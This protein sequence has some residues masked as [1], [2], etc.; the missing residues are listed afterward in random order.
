MKN[1]VLRISVSLLGLILTF[2]ILV[3]LSY[4][5]QP[6]LQA[7]PDSVLF[8]VLVVFTSVAGVP[9]GGGTASLLPMAIV[10]SYL[11]LG[12]LPAAWI[13]FLSQLLAAIIEPQIPGP[14]V[15]ARPSDRITFITRFSTNAALQTMSILIAGTL[16]EK[17]GGQVPLMAVELPDIVPLLALG[18]TFLL[19]NYVG[20]GL[21][22][23]SRGRTQ[24]ETYIRAIDGLFGYEGIPLS[25]APL[26]ALVATRLGTWAFLSLTVGIMAV[27]VVARSLA[28]TSLRLQRRV[29]ELD[30]LLEVSQALSASL[31]LKTILLAIHAQI[32]ELMPAD[33]FYLALYNPA[34]NE[35]SFPLYIED[36][37]EI[38]R[39]A[40]R[41]GRGLTEY[42]LK[43]GKPLLS[44]ETTD[45]TRRKLGLQPATHPAL[46]WLGVPIL[47]GQ[48]PIGVIA[49]QSYLDRHLYDLNHQKVLAAVAAQAGIAIQNTQLFARTDEALAFRVQ[50]LNSILRATQDGI[51]FL[52]QQGKVLAANRALAGFLHV[53]QLELLAMELVTPLGSDGEPLFGLIGYQWEELQHDLQLILQGDCEPQKVTIHL[54]G[55]PDRYL[56]RTLTGVRGE[57]GEIT[58]WLFV[59]RDRTD[60]VKAARMQEDL[61]QMIVHDLPAPLGI[62]QGGL[63]MVT[64]IHPRAESEPKNI[65]QENDQVVALLKKSTGR[66]VG[67]VDQLLDIHKLESGELELSCQPVAVKPFLE[68]VAEPFTALLAEAE[69]RF[70]IEIG[71]DLPDLMIDVQY[72]ARVISNLLD[73]ALKF[74]PDRGCIQL[75]AVVEL[76]GVRPQV[77]ISLHD[78]GTGIPPDVKPFLFQKYRQARIQQGR[79]AGTG[80]G[81][82]FCKLVV[83]AHGGKIWADS[84]P[85][86]G[87]TFFVILPGASFS[88]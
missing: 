55:I 81:L 57:F 68:E 88:I 37:Q 23:A 21:F 11:T 86:Q 12:L 84:S 9:V 5:R 22:I 29:R 85:G 67:L 80:L 26:V 76:D 10:A 3:G 2:G 16:Y 87:S 25:F 50:Q 1:N 82:Y 59:F 13:A 65:L 45:E 47:S 34:L 46:S 53:A 32:A 52:D 8:L 28:F 27:A 43:T 40:R 61:Q 19:V 38:H 78:T 51:L 56:E 77:C 48:T 36:G 39:Q 7:A 70:E 14:E 63:D 35:V 18:M 60:E 79:R 41:A 30:A 6:Q 72:M 44:L 74:T 73:N 75:G 17:I 4:T 33:Y 20:V 66:M 83:E 42:I 31:D 24:L 62:I 54:E 69:I 71:Q 58:G 15:P 64:S 49:V